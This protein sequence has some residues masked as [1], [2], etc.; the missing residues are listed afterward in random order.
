MR[1]LVLSD[2]WLP[3]P[4]GAERLIYNLACSIADAGYDVA[5]LTGYEH[6]QQFNGPPV[7]VNMDMPLDARGSMMVA[8]AIDA[9]EPDVI[10]TH[11]I[12]ARA[13]APMLGSLPSET[14]IVQI[15]LNGERLPF[16]ALAVY[17]SEWVRAQHGD[18]QPQDLVITPMARH[19]V[20][21]D[22][23][24]DAIGFIKPIAH[25]GVELVYKV[26]RQL[27]RR[28]FVIL[29]G[30]WQ[31]LEIIQPLR[32]VEF[33]EPVDD[34]RDFWREVR[35]VL[36]PSLSED[37][38]TVAQEA[39]ANEVP[40]ISSDVQGLNETNAGGYRISPQRTGAWVRTIRRLD[41]PALYAKMVQ[42]QRD[43]EASID[44]AG[45]IRLLLERMEEVCAWTR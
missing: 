37:A 1:V 12:Y 26:A 9:Y 17:I 34:I 35:L 22:T 15:V 41:D 31:D 25:K 16:A 38:G 3:F 14:P 40:C 33:M 43:H 2:L 27:P 20:V 5:V 32:N 18:A 11:H 44:R 19:D 10:L 7:T 36:V 28:R 42:R 23:H 45:Q 39:T 24:G 21:A 29:R 13:F 6:A 30:E 4:G 8:A